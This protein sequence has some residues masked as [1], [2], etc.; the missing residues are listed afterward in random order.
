[1]LGQQ[2]LHLCPGGQRLD[3]GQQALVELRRLR[4]LLL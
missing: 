2:L 3:L 1:V 4:L